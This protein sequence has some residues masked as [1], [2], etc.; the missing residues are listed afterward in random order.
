[1]SNT[2]VGPQLSIL[3]LIRDPAISYLKTVVQPPTPN[4][5]IVAVHGLNIP[6]HGKPGKGESFGINTWVAGESDKPGHAK[7]KKLWLKDFLPDRFPR[8]RVMIFGYNSNVGLNTSTAGVAGAADDLLAKLTHKRRDIEDRPILFAVCKARSNPQYKVLYPHIRSI[9]FFATPHRGGLHAELGQA[10]AGGLRRLTGNVRSSVMESLRP[11]SFTAPEIHRSFRDCLSDNNIRVCSFYEARPMRPLVHLIVDQNSA[12]LGLEFPREVQYL[13][14][15]STHSSICKFESKTENY[16]VIID[17]LADLVDY[18]LGNNIYESRSLTDSTLSLSRSRASSLNLKYTSDEFEE[19]RRT[20]DYFGVELD[21]HR[22]SSPFGYRGQ[23]RDTGPWFVLP[24]IEIPGF[25][26]RESLFE[27]IQ[28]ALIHETPSQTRIALHGLGGV[29]KTQLALKVIEWYRSSFPQ[30]SIFWLRASNITVF[31]QSLED[32]AAQCNIVSLERNPRKVLHSVQQHLLDARNGRWLIIADNADNY[33]SLENPSRFSLQ[34]SSQSTSKFR[35]IPMA[36]MIPR[37]AHGRILFT[38]N[39]KVIANQL[40]APGGEAIEVALMSQQESKLL[41]QRQL[42]GTS[43]SSTSP[44]SYEQSLPSNEDLEN[45]A[46]HLGNLPLAIAQA[47]AYMRQQSLTAA[48]YLKL[49]LV[50]DSSLSDLI[51][52]DFQ[53]YG[54]EDEFSK[55]I[56]TTWNAA[57][58]SIERDCPSAYDM[59]SFMAFLEPQSIPRSLLKELQPDERQLTAI[60]LGTLQAYALIS[61][62]PCTGNC[63]LHRLVQLAIRKRLEVKEAAAKTST[64]ALRILATC[65]PDKEER[66]LNLAKGSELLPHALKVLS[67]QFT[68]SDVTNIQASTL[69]SNISHYYTYQGDYNEAIRQSR[70]AD[71]YLAKVI[72]PHRRLTL[73]NQATQVWA[74]RE[75]GKTEETLELAKTVWLGN[76]KEYGPSADTTIRSHLVLGLLYQDLGRYKECLSIAKHCVK[77]LQKTNKEHGLPLL[78]A[79]SRLGRSHYFLGN[80]TESENILREVLTHATQELG[81]EHAETLRIR[82]RYAFAVLALG[83]AAECNKLC[84]ENWAVQNAALGEQHPDVLKTLNLKAMALQE[85]G[86]YEAAVR[87]HRRIYRKATELAGPDHH[88]TLKAADCL[89]DALSAWSASE[90]AA[91][92]GEILKEAQDLYNQNLQNAK[93]KAHPDTLRMQSSLA[94]ILRLRGRV[95]EAKT[96]QSE[97]CDKLQSALGKQHPL[98][99]DASENLARCLKDLGKEKEAVKLAKAVL[100][101]REKA[102]GWEHYATVRTAKLVLEL[103]PHGKKNGKLRARV[104]GVEPEV[105]ARLARAGSTGSGGSGVGRSSLDPSGKLQSAGLYPSSKD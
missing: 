101:R 39:S 40:V 98:T 24:N 92:S 65:F 99:L 79:K 28:A 54:I 23:K 30:E 73:S 29:G 91:S 31:S 45:L 20:S 37:C 69:C 97:A 33:D 80:Y 66:G 15:E 95:S 57:F 7:F 62:E 44:P 36:T 42:D 10:A 52:H 50:S 100:E 71:V 61:F 60:S 82:H 18:S 88:H 43:R 84:S 96:L 94:N 81:P 85:L 72:Q 26:G 38:T 104:A 76:K 74:L 21:L 83:R 102:L 58:D 55:A 9:A 12:V 93:R 4:I 46:T 77:S 64:T 1:M 70:T 75:A 53:G 90:N 13:V 22:S 87:Y 41:L 34:T 78:H 8:A 103:E 25:V 89:A 17:H 16:E 27:T 67:S 35:R 49:I 19:V 86:D 2:V 6:F 48:T 56:A 63:S 5:D 11:D 105:D 59:L 14:P 3:D 32:V 47:A 51:D 68:E